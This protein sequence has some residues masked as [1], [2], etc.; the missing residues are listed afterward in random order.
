MALDTA[1]KRR[2]MFGMGIMA[3]VIAPVAD[4][5]LSSVDRLHIMGL[6]G[7]IT[8]AAVIGIVRPLI[9]GSLADAMLLGR[10][11]VT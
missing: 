7:A 6:P 2:S 5:D 3:L 9:H 8:P 4:G 1:T 11:L 10:G